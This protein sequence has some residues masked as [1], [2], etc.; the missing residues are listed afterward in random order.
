V[1]ETV[2]IKRSHGEDCQCEVSASAGPIDAFHSKKVNDLTRSQGSTQK[3]KR[4]V[5]NSFLIRYILMSFV[6][7]WR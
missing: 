2:Q 7:S 4:R 3:T 6:Y 5:S 1:R